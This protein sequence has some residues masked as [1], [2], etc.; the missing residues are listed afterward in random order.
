MSTIAPPVEDVIKK[1]YTL[2]K[3]YIERVSSFA[4]NHK[5][6][7]KRGAHST[8]PN[9]SAALRYIL[10]VFFGRAS[11]LLDEP[12]KQDTPTEPQEQSLEPAA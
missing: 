1:Q 11:N 2:P 9:D 7:F 6:H 12:I 5:E 4:Y 10:D 8:H 3:E